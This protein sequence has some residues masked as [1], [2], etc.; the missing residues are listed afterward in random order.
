V[1]RCLIW[2]AAVAAWLPAGTAIARTAAPQP[3]PA[4]ATAP[5][6]PPAPVSETAPLTLQ[7]ALTQARANA[8][9]ARAALTAA[10]LAT[11]DRKQ[12]RAAL[13][14]ALSEF[15]GYYYT[16]PN[17]LPSGVWVPNDGTLYQMWL[18]V[19]EDIFAPSKWAQYRSAS[20]A[21]AVARAKAE[22]EAS[23]GDREQRCERT[24]GAALPREMPVV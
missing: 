8:Q 9:Q 20:A 14:P 11:E 15:N 16:Q 19:H 5:Q 17:G 18:T 10:N 2:F 1:S 24:V 13:L 3:P 22:G 4:S 12:A 7:A 6:A 23:N 21:E